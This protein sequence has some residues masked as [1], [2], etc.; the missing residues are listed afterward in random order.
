M[1]TAQLTNITGITRADRRH[2]LVLHYSY[3]IPTL[4]LP[5]AK[6]LLGDWEASGVTLVLVGIRARS[7][8]RH[9]ARRRENIDPS[10]SGVFRAGTTIA[11]LNNINSRCELTGEPIFQVNR[12][13]NLAEEDQ[14]HFNPA[15]FRRPLPNGKVGNF[16][17]AP[18]GVLRHPGYSNWDFTLSRR[19]RIGATRERA[20][21]GSGVQPVQPG[22]V[23]RAE[24]GLPIRGERREHVAGHRQVHDDD[25]SKERGSDASVRLLAD[26]GKRGEG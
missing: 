12:D 24:R 15:A 8:L 16:G 10:L 25:E 20:A 7:D 9:D 2:S 14:M 21:A 26:R 22:R 18:V 23:H 13:P 4:N 17:N 1:T 6:Y 19:F 3:E 5:I 11:D